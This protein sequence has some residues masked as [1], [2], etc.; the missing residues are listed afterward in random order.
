MTILAEADTTDLF[1]P[2]LIVL[3]VIALL[4]G[5]IALVRKRMFSEAED[6]TDDPMTGF[7]LSSLRQLVKDGKMTQDEFDAAKA[8]IVAN[9]Q[10]AAER[11]TPVK[12]LA[13]ENKVDPNQPL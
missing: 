8:Q 2:T 7:S 11:A 10:R 5:A 6:L 1:I 4:I 12:D 13:P 3:A 9:T